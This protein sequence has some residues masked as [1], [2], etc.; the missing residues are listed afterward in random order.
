MRA[1]A[2]MPLESAV[3][4]EAVEVVEVEAEGGPSHLLGFEGDHP[5]LLL[6]RSAV[7]RLRD[8]LQ[9]AVVPRLQLQRGW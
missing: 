4:V 6:A 5:Q 8:R 7:E 3:V 1:A 9:S 2:T